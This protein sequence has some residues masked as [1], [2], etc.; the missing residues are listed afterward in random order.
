[1]NDKNYSVE[2]EQILD[3]TDQLIQ[4]SD[5]AGFRM[6]YANKPAIIFARHSEKPY[7]GEK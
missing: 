4:I 5:R 3:D 2:F 6:L 1:M 7:R